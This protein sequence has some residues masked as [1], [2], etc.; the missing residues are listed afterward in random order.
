MKKN[1][2]LLLSICSLLFITQSCGDSK[3]KI[4]LKKMVIELNKNCP[5][6]FDFATCIGARV[7]DGN[8]VMDYV[9]D[10][11]A[12]RLDHLKDQSEKN[13]RHLAESFLS[14]K[15]ELGNLLIRAGYGY[16]A[17]FKGSKTKETISV[18]LTTDEIKQ[19]MENPASKNDILNWE[20][21]ITNS[22]L[23]MQIDEVTTLVCVDYKG[24]TISYIYEIDDEQI[25]MSSMSAVKDDIKEN[26][27][28]ELAQDWNSPTSTSKDFFTL[29]CRTNKALSYVYRGKTTGKEFAIVFSNGELRNISHD[30]IE[31]E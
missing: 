27:R 26:L 8:L 18:H 22:M 1:I 31:E 20:V 14:T 6:E 7:E 3:A 13:K 29:A 10:E 19:V 28:Q 30:Y 21:Q 15:D 11:D 16:A 2:I 12:I 25:N 23:P 17:Y 4:E 5:I 9:Y 24:A